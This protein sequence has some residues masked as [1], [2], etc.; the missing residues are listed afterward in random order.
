MSSKSDLD[1]AE[2]DLNFAMGLYQEKLAAFVKMAK[3]TLAATISDT[4][5][6]S[7]TPGSE[8]I[9]PPLKT[10]PLT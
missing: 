4:G 8:V 2:A 9:D 3:E 5:D 7:G 6:F 1:A 10:G